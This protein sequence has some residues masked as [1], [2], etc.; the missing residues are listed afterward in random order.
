M[1]N[2]TI[3]DDVHEVLLVVGLKFIFCKIKIDKYYWTIHYEITMI[4]YIKRLHGTI[5]TRFSDSTQKT[6]IDRI[7]N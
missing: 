6:G 3:S 2:F 1:S 4:A 5:A 7:K